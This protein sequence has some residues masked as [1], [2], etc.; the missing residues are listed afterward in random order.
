MKSAQL[1]AL[2]SPLLEVIG[3]GAIAF[4]VWYGGFLVIDGQM[5]PGEFFS[6]LAAM[7]LAYAPIKKLASANVLVQRAIAA[8][9]RVFEM[10]D[11][12]HE[13]VRDPGRVELPAISRSMEFQNVS[14]RYEGSDEPAIEHIRLTVEFGEVVALVGKSGSGKSTLMSLVPRFH[15]PSEGR[16]LI[17]GQDIRDVTLTSLRAQIAIVSQE[18]ILFDE[19][20]RANIAYGC[21]EASEQEIV[22]AARAGHAWEFIEEL[23][24]GL[25]TMIGE[26]GVNLSGG[27]RQRLAIA[28]AMLRNPPLLI[29]DEATS[30]LDTES[31]RKIQAALAELMKNRTTLVIAHRLS[32]VQ[33][34]DRIVVLD[35]GRMVEEGIHHELLGRNGV[36]TRLYQTQFHDVPAASTLR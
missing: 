15:D 28:R 23:P 25:D 18:T 8:A 4:V 3:I 31:E 12:D 14:F 24:G 32:T 6:F 22:R 20:V 2:S 10:L 33:H 26:N 35:E 1:A 16:I 7:F 30:A 19:T 9:N 11:R 36:Y 17:D 13:F 27:Q 21:P 29:L 5:K 34:A